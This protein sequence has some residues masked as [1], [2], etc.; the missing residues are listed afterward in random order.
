MRL[1]RLLLAVLLIALVAGCSSGPSSQSRR[2]GRTNAMLER[3]PTV[4]ISSRQF[5]RAIDLKADGKCHEA[6]P[7]FYRMAIRGEGFE[8]AQYHLADCLL[9]DAPQSAV[10]SAYLDALLWMRRAAEAGSPEAQAALAGLY[11]QG[12]SG[13]RNREEAAMWY[14]LYD[15]NPARKRPGFVPIPRER[16]DE[17]EAAIADSRQAGEAR[18]SAWSKTIWT[19]P[20]GAMPP[21]S[22]GPSRQDGGIEM[23]TPDGGNRRRPPQGG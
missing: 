7:L 23:L 13:I 10:N 4:D 17:I 5:S 2:Q 19:P 22:E 18:A 1:P 3:I 20:T 8:L 14:A 12:P 15:A 21:A 6:A 9:R 11:A 16:A